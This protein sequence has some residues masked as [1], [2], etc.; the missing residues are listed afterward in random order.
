LLAN[1]TQICQ[2]CFNTVM[3]YCGHPETTEFD[4]PLM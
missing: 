4:I 2:V 3:H 1:F